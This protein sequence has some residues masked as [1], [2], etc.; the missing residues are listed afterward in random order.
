MPAVT[1]SAI[2]QAL[3]QV[4]DRELTHNVVELG[5]IQEV[6]IV[7]DH[8]HLAI[9]LTTPHCPFAERIVDNIRAAVTQLPRVRTVD[10]ARACTQEN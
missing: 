7:G 4:L 10:G 1:E 9:Q 6:E 2:L 8:L 5:F 3:S